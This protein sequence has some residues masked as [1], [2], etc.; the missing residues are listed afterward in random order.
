MT[1]PKI[2]TTVF[3]HLKEDTTCDQDYEWAEILFDDEQVF[4]LNDDYHDKSIYQFKGF[5]EAC[6]LFWGDLN[7]IVRRIKVVADV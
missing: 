2:I 1:K 6:S 3:H 7:G 5:I 4:K